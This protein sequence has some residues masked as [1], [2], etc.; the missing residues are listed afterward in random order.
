MTAKLERQFY[1]VIA[2]DSLPDPGPL[3]DAMLQEPHFIDAVATLRIRLAPFPG[4]GFQT[5]IV[6]GNTFIFYNPDN[7]NDRLAPDCYAA[8]DVDADAIRA[9]NGYLVW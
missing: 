6:S 7:L 2:P 9:Q 3:P 8:F 5:T 4:A 1:P